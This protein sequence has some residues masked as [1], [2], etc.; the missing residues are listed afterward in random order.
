[1]A[2]LGN[3]WHLPLQPEPPIRSTMRI[4]LD[5][6]VP[7][8]AISITTGNQFAGD[9]GNPGNQLQ[10]GSAL[11]FR[12]QSDANWTTLPMFF[13]SMVG[14]NKYYQATILADTFAANDVVDYYL[15]IRYSDHDITFLMS[16][17][18]GSSTTAD[19]TAA[20]AAPFTLTV[21]S[22]TERGEWS[23]VFGVTNVGIH[24]HVLPSGEVLMWG[25]RDDPDP[26][27]SLDAHECTPFVWNP[28][29]GT[30]AGAFTDTT[31]QP[32]QEDGTTVNL[33]CSGH[34]VLP[35]GTLLVVG[36][37]LHD[38]VGV[39]QAALYD[40]QKAEWE[41]LAEM[42]D[43]RWYPT[44]LTLSDGGALVLSG[45]TS[46]GTGPDNPAPINPN[47]QVWQ[48]GAWA[49]VNGLSVTQGS[50]ELFPRVHV[51]SDGSVVMTGPQATTWSLKNGSWAPIAA[52]GR[53][54]GRRD[55]A[56]SVM[57]DVDKIIYIGGGND[58][59]T[60]QP[61]ANAEVLDLTVVA[62]QWKPTAKPMNFPR[63]Q[64]NATIL[65][66]G[67]VLVTGGTQGGGGPGPGF[68]DLT[69][70]E[71][72]HVAELWDPTHDTWTLL[73]AELVDR[74]YHST[75]VLLPDG[76]VLSA[77]GGEYSPNENGIPNP[78][79]D[80]HRDAQIFSP[81]YLFNGER[82]QLTAV[83]ANVNYGE[84]FEVSTPT[85]GDI[86]RVSWVRLSST[87]HSFNMNQRINFLEFAVDGAA[88]KVTAPA[89]AN[90]CPPGHYMLFLLSHAGVPSV[91]Q[92]VQVAQAAGAGPALAQAAAGEE[93]L[94]VGPGA[95]A[96]PADAFARRDAV[97][98]EAHGTQVLVGVVSTC[99]YGIGACWGGAHEA[100]LRLEGVQ[101]VDPIPNAR[102]STATVFLEGHGLPALDR[103]GDQFRAVV[104]GTYNFRGVEVTLK[105]T[106]DQHDSQLV[107]SADGP[108][109]AVALEPLAA[110]DKVQWL[111]PAAGPQP[112]LPEEG[113]AY[114]RL[115]AEVAQLGAGSNVTV[116]GPLRLEGDSYR[117]EVRRFDTT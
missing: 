19:E 73:A 85:P 107:L 100:L 74:C 104:G 5:P 1:M 111:G 54:S 26:N 13:L 102:D 86:G 27:A 90:I 31:N 55:Y 53:E 108:R 30:D 16:D 24:A 46:R 80:T 22:S 116:T 37:H 29:A 58:P 39:N 11:L 52:P 8:T 56:P 66:D 93:A 18:A 7:G 50:F 110:G 63:R 2:N 40:A 72:V 105:G 35:D 76:R 88:L 38:S 106:F 84:T 62:P 95:A 21:E 14:N 67:T 69:P 68:N 48:N 42:N 71:P 113:S 96:A 65:A 60:H 15:R 97:L 6:L 77:G 33:F 3:A 4:P 9:A 25:R 109:P 10:D 91:A 49:P 117:L 17:G 28:A 75:A 61:T 99:P 79:E 78:P 101:G 36:G 51:A 64:H 115:R 45:N 112:V 94:A 43:G 103:W 87:T 70:A 12:R 41:P 20:Q 82:P 32:K 59:D 23:P 92:I 98:R 44:A 114:E 57:Y 83:P 47:P 81:S 89:S 34:T